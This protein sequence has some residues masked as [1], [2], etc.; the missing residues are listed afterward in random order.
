[1]ALDPVQLPLE[2]E[3]TADS[4]K[5]KK[6]IKQQENDAKDST[7]RTNEDRVK[8]RRKQLA[9]SIRQVRTNAKVEEQLL[10][11]QLRLRIVSEKA[12]AKKRLQI[13]K[14]SR[15]EINKIR[16]ITTKKGG[17]LFSGFGDVSAGVQAIAFATKQIVNFGTT[18]LRQAANLELFDRRARI[19]FEESLPKVAEAAKESAA[20]IGLTRAEFTAAAS[21]AGDLLKPIGFTAD[22]AA[23]S[24]IEFLNL[25]G[26]LKEFNADSRSVDEINRIITK[27]LLGERDALTS[28]GIKISEAEIQTRLL[29]KGQKKLTGQM[30][31]L[32]KA[33]VTQELLFEKS[34]DAL[35]SFNEE[36]FK[37]LSRTLNEIDAGFGTAMETLSEFVGRGLAPLAEILLAALTNFNSFLEVLSGLD[38]A[39][40]TIVTLTTAITALGIAMSFVF[41]P[42]PLIIAAAAAAFGGLAIVIDSLIDKN[43]TLGKQLESERVALSKLIKTVDSLQ[44]VQ[45]KTIEQTRTLALA[46]SQLRDEADKL[47]ISLFNQKGELIGIAKAQQLIVEA[48]KKRLQ[49]D[50][51]QRR[52]TLLPLERQVGV[53]TA[54][55]KISKPFEKG[56]QRQIKNFENEIQAA[57]RAGNIAAARSLQITFATTRAGRISAQRQAIAQLEK[58][59]AALDKKAATKIEKRERGDGKKGAEARAQ[60]E[61]FDDAIIILDFRLEQISKEKQ[62]RIKLAE[63]IRDEELKN[64]K[65]LNLEKKKKAAEE[66]RIRSDLE[67]KILKIS[68]DAQAKKQKSLLSGAQAVA[69]GA[70]ELAKGEGVGGARILG[71]ITGTDVAG[72]FGTVKSIAESIESIFSPVSDANE[73]LLIQEK[74]RQEQIKITN[75]LIKR[76]RDLQLELLELKNKE[77]QFIATDAQRQIRVNTLLIENSQ[78]RDIANLKVI[79]EAINE[80]SESAD[81]PTGPQGLVTFLKES[82]RKIEA[83]STVISGLTGFSLPTTFNIGAPELKGKFDVA[84]QTIQQLQRAEN[85]PD[86]V[87][88]A[89]S[90]LLSRVNQAE[91][92][93]RR[94]LAPSGRIGATV[95]R[96]KELSEFLGKINLGGRIANLRTIQEDLRAQT[97]ASDSIISLLEQQNQIEESQAQALELTQA[98]EKSFV[99]VGRGGVREAF[100]IFTAPTVRPAALDLPTGAASVALATR[101]AK[102]FSERQAD[103]LEQV[104]AILGDQLEILLAIEDNTRQGGAETFGTGEQDI[105]VA[106]IL[107]RI[108]DRK[109]AA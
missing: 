81:I 69:T 24:A 32:A 34:K 49:A 10:K 106:D 12:F 96:G 6:A 43:V 55:G 59:L 68:L 70:A 53:R 83:L 18:A 23:D 103:S 57:A 19:V 105:V 99:D 97:G 48:Q 39:T 72:A 11:K 51:A 94:F 76:E 66:L 75:D 14:Q 109:I 44:K 88:G 56:L 1:M 101:A 50:I 47:N 104:V 38:D 16:G 102:S 79:Q 42:I 28:F 27:S 3:L 22:Q 60:A 71:A 37:P 67:R 7:K 25:S 86:E 36:G 62:A 17:G 92:L 52:A 15:Q 78:T 87:S 73:K 2:F 35:T 84:R 13:Q 74:L 21:A 8:G 5:V 108:A 85:L 58:D 95:A 77:L 29:E 45:K 107:D 80:I 31:L 63:S 40:A 9:E 82:T 90:S 20:A 64:L 4:G 91:Q 41:G 33:T 98:R 30:L 89:L 61:R 46:E 26:A 54:A 65:K 100:G 93:R